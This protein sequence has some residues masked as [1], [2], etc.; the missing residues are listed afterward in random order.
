MGFPSVR[1]KRKM[2]EQH[3]GLSAIDHEMDVVA[4]VTG[5]KMRVA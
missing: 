1:Q 2:G 4:V 5:F 3:A